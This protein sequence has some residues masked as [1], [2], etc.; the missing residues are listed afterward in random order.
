MHE[1]TGCGGQS[2]A[3]KHATLYQHGT[4]SAMHRSADFCSANFQTEAVV[5]PNAEDDKIVSQRHIP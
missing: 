4:E 2:F 1:T 3:A 5:A